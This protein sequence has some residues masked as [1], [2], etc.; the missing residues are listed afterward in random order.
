MPE[1]AGEMQMSG[2]FQKGK[3]GNPNGKARGSKNR[4]TLAAE[5]LL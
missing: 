1:N 2:K 4:A 3:S 5:H